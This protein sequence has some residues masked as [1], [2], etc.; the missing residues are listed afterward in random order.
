MQKHDMHCQSVSGDHNG[1]H[2]SLAKS[3]IIT[4]AKQQLEWNGQ[5]DEYFKGF[6]CDIVHSID[7]LIVS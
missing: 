6:Q 7:V 3:W 2:G 5:H 4:L 1:I